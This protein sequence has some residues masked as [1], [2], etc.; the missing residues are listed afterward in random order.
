MAYK[1]YKCWRGAR[2]HQILAVGFLEPVS[3]NLIGCTESNTNPNITHDYRPFC[4]SRESESSQHIRV[5]YSIIVFTCGLYWRIIH[6]FESR[7]LWNNSKQPDWI[8]VS[9]EY[10]YVSKI[11]KTGK[12][13]AV[14][15]ETRC[16]K[17]NG[18]T[19]HVWRHNV[20]LIID[21]RSGH[22]H[23]IVLLKF[24][25]ATSSWP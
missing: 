14:C 10:T 13:I 15:K 20:Y 2:T 4:C 18:K 9:A 6:F 24:L 5:K 12:L 16:W 23:I 1:R 21:T 25:S 7:I 8:Y 19:E 3:Q 11:W 17:I 22:G